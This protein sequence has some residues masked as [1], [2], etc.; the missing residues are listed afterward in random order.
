MEIQENL[1]A[2]FEYTLTDSQGEAI[3]ASNGEPLAY[4][5]GHGNIIP[6]LEKQMLGKKVGDKFTAEVPAEEGYGIVQQELI[7]AV[8]KEMFQGVETLEVGMRFE[9]QTEYGAHS[10]EITEIEGDEITVDG[11]HPLAGVDLV[12]EI[13]VTDVREATAEEIEHGHAHGAGGVH[14]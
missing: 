1:V 10:V 4:L 6:G 9:A 13:E 12:F 11:N 5:H 7:Q 14:H 8:P 3:D 2:I